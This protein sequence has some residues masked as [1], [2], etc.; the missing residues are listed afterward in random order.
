[1]LGNHDE[2]TVIGRG[3]PVFD[4]VWHYYALILMTFLLSFFVAQACIPFG[5]KCT[6]L[7]AKFKVGSIIS[8]C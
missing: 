6:I 2:S 5:E 3:L 1:V 4:K 7:D 8:D